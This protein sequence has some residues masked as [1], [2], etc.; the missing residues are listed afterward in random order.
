LVLVFFTVRCRTVFHQ[1][2]DSQALLEQYASFELGRGFFSDDKLYALAGWTYIRGS[3]P[4]TI[5]FEHPPFAKYLIGL[6]ELAFANHTVLGLITSVLTLIVLYL[7]SKNILHISM[8]AIIPPLLL[9][10]DKMYIDFSSVSML[11]IYATFFSTLSLLLLLSEK[12]WT[13]PLLGISMGLALSCKWTA[14]FLLLLPIAYYAFNR[15]W[16]AL[17]FYPL[18]LL[19]VAVTYT[20]TYSAYF[21]AGHSVL[22]FIS[23]QW[24]M[25]E[26]HQH[27]HFEGG[28]KPLWIL[29]NFL[30]GV[31]GPTRIQ[32]LLLDSVNRTVTVIGSAEGLSLIQYYSPLTWPTSFSSSLLCLYYSVRANR[33]LTPIPL[34]FMLLIASASIGKPFIWYLLPGLPLGLISLTYV[35]TATYAQSEN[36]H[37][38][39]IFLAVYLASV[40]FWSL[41]VDLPPYVVT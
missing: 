8:M 41:F 36:R 2:F 12:K 30:T 25:V 22:D 1:S 10:L 19:V 37:L 24:K 11:D 18:C 40:V 29:M 15:K 5:N 3:S 23:L 20:V 33:R 16:K 14:V 28:P 4:D 7:V 26:F 17:R 21:A 34:G 6:S 39:G 27:R 32:T 31:E 9:S 35:I 13:M 38:A